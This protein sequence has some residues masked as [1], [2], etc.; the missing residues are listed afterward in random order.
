MVAKDMQQE[1]KNNN[2]KTI[3]SQLVSLQNINEIYTFYLET[4]V[5]FGLYSLRIYKGRYS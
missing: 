2:L 5:L 4:R 3:K 1:I